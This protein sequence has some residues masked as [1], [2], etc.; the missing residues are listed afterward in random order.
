MLHGR[1]LFE[2][3][4]KKHRPRH[5]QDLYDADSLSRTF[6]K[7]TSYS[8]QMTSTARPVELFRTFRNR[9]VSLASLLVV[10]KYAAIPASVMPEIAQPAGPAR[11]VPTKNAETLAM[12]PAPHPSAPPIPAAPP[13]I[14][15]APL[16]NCSRSRAEGGRM[17][18]CTTS[19]SSPSTGE[20]QSPD[21]RTKK[22]PTCSLQHC[23]DC[24]PEIHRQT[25]QINLV[26][27]SRFVLASP[28][29]SA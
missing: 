23:C 11:D 13:P 9:S 10:A 22:S 4:H 12:T 25:I 6:T 3:C 27:E 7:A 26:I 24:A 16:I 18:S 2:R 14:P 15:N 1:C 5:H 20:N 8:G 19:N 28:T 17:P 21:T 29:H